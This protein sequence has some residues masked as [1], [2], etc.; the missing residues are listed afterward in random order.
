M[1]TAV[2]AWLGIPPAASWIDVGCGTGA[3]AGVIAALASPRRLAGIDPSPGFLATATAR[4]GEAFD[5]RVGDARSLPFDSDEFDAAVSG[6]A[7]NFVPEPDVAVREMRRVTR[8]GGTVAAYVW[9]YA[10]GMQMIRRFWDV[11]IALDPT[12]GHLDE[13]TRFPHCRPN[14]LTDLFTHAGL[15]D[16]EVTAQ[17]IPTVFDHFDDYWRPFL[18]GQGPAPSYVMSLS[19]AARHRLRNHL[20]EAL[21]TSPAGEIA[22]TARAWAVRGTA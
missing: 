19:E 20:E 18:G 21:P 12:I 10:D 5:A 2:V 16:I 11:A 14:P 3:L 8:R 22:L 15:E 6:I 17:E 4:L 9:D 13:A 1:A 7:L